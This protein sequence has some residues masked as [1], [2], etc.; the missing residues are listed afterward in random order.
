MNPLLDKLDL[1]ITSP[2]FWSRGRRL[3]NRCLAIRHVPKAN[4]SPCRC[5]GL[6]KGGSP[7]TM[8]SPVVMVIHD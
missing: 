2:E 7:V 6:E 1:V 8:G 5:R 3:A 4:S